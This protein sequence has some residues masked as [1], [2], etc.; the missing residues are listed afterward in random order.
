MSIGFIG[1][2]NIGAPM[3]RQLLKLGEEVCVFDVDESRMRP[4]GAQGARVAADV[5]ELAERCRIIG[6]CVRDE[7]D[8]ERVLRGADGLLAH[9]ASQTIVA[10]HSTVTQA[11]LLAWVSAAGERGVQ[12]IDAPITGGAA[13]AEAA[14]LTYMVGADAAVLELCRPVFMTSAHHIIHA[15]PVGAGLLLKLCNNLMSYAAFAAMHEAERLARAG[16]LDPA[17]LIEVGRDNGVVTAQMAAFMSNRAHLAATGPHALQRAFAPFAAL[18]QKDLAAALQSARELEVTLP[19]TER[20]AE[21]IS[22]VFLNQ[23][24]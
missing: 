4:L 9:A 12:L 22:N 20:V 8:V 3:A 10:L 24:N 18:A 21:I 13:G 7:A 23:D 14:T 5:R 17:L 16:H 11:A 6:V 2:G 1:L 15:G 19:A